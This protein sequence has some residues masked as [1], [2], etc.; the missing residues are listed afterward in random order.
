MLAIAPN[1]V[2]QQIGPL[3]KHSGHSVGGGEKQ[4]PRRQGA[5]GLGTTAGD[6]CH[7]ASRPAVLRTSGK[8]EHR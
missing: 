1:G 2:K 7:P 3:Q 5:P 8:I 6:L 4:I